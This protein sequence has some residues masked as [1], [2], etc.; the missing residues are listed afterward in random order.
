MTG[1]VQPAIPSAP[2]SP[3]LLPIPELDYRWVHAGAQ[4]LDLLPTPI[5]TASTSYKAFSADESRRIEEAWQVLEIKKRRRAIAEWG[6][7]EGEGAPTKVKKDKDKGGEGREGRDTAGST[8]PLDIEGSTSIR[9]PTHA[10]PIEEQLHDDKDEKAKPVKEV[11]RSGEELADVETKDDKYRD[12]MLKQQRDYED[13]ELVVGVPVS[14]VGLKLIWESVMLSHRYRIP[15]S[16]YHY[17]RYHYIRCS[18]LRLDPESPFSGVL[19]S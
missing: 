5:T 18:G 17:P 1:S 2:S 19:G 10:H 11:L 7:T 13:L 12:Y 3:P 9:E 8:A 14:E 15:F 4:H 16:R 6:Q